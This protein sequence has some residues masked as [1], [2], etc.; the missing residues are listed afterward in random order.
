MR[1]RSCSDHQAGE[2]Q[3]GGA[4]RVPPNWKSLGYVVY[5]HLMTNGLVSHSFSCL[6]HSKAFPITGTGSAASSEAELWRSA[7]GPSASSESSVSMG[8]HGQRK[9]INCFK[10]LTEVEILS[11]KAQGW[12]LQAKQTLCCC[13]LPSV[14]TILCKHLLPDVEMPKSGT[15]A[16]G[17]GV[18]LQRNKA[19]EFTWMRQRMTLRC[20]VFNALNDCCFTSPQQC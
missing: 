6:L 19:Q 15:R 14:V 17:L 12:I 16:Q 13:H 4:S 18:S 7:S 10:H 3:N 20:S 2:Q 1:V 11:T 9:W 8:T 5:Q